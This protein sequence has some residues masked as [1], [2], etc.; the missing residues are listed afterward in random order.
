MLLKL[1]AV[2]S[3]VEQLYTCTQRALVAISNGKPPPTLIRTVLDQLSTVPKKIEQMK[4]SAARSG[5]ITALS[6]AKAWQAELDPAEMATGCPGLKEDGSTFDQADFA[7]CVKEMRPLACKLAEESDLSKYQ[8]AYNMENTRIRAPTH[9]VVDLTPPTRK[10]TFAPDIDPSPI[11]NDE[12]IF[13]ALT[14]IDW[15]SA[16]LQMVDDEEAAQDDG[17]PSR[18]QEEN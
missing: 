6:R 14:G 10:H 18:D 9:D 13:K 16:D 15:T 1:K 5:T 7:K 8:L 11:I 2:Y 4:L 12:A 17:E 3:L